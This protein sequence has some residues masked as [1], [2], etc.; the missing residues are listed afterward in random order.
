MKNSDEKRLFIQKTWV[1]ALFATI[2]TFFWGSA[3]PCIKI[4]YRLFEIDAGDTYGQICFAGIRFAIAGVM[5]I[6][7][8]SIIG[9]KMLLPG[10]KSGMHIAVL[11]LFQTVLQYFF[12]YVGLA[13]T[14]GVKS[15][16]INGSGT[17]LAILVASL[18]FHHEKLSFRKILGC[19]LGF[20]GVI[21]VNLSGNGMDMNVTLMG[22]GFI[23]LCALSYAVSSSLI[24]TFSKT[25]NPVMLS[26]YQFLLGGI[27]LAALGF[28]GGGRISVLSGKGL[29]ML[30]YL[31]FVS[32][33]SYTLWGL[34]LKYNPLSKVAIFGF[35]N[36][37]FG[38]IL[39]SWW[40]GESADFSL[41]VL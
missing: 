19:S 11:S 40:L 17:F 41:K 35:A 10:K 2:C 27:V 29:L 22:E 25:D 20:L 36:P 15:S 4:G 33:F 3:F 30:L 24:K 37:L 18:I 13:R 32:A 31:A 5:V 7:V 1:V 39:S 28:A 14:S 12:F 26:G 16:I 8:Q 38:V 21:T 6:I 34:L 23:L 9:R